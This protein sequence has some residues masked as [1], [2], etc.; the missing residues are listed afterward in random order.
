ML[1][2]SST[3][4][5]AAVPPHARRCVADWLCCACLALSMT[6]LAIRSSVGT[7][8]LARLARPLEL[9]AAAA[10]AAAA[11]VSLVAPAASLRSLAAI[12]FPSPSPSLYAAEPLAYPSPPSPSPRPPSVAPLLSRPS[13]PPVELWTRY[14]GPNCFGGHGA[15]DIDMPPMCR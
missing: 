11:A 1:L 5:P 9:A 14:E 13:P 12:L 3:N 10:A 6:G 7:G 2:T 8:K 15:E 4:A